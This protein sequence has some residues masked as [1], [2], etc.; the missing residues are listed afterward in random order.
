MFD[1]RVVPSLR[2]GAWVLKFIVV[3]VS[4]MRETSLFLRLW[5]QVVAIKTALSQPCRAKE[6]A[7]FKADFVSLAKQ[8]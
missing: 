2:A 6:R 5:A 4:L 7:R 1:C 3:Y 8:L